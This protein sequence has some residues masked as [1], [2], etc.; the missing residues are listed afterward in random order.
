MPT[1]DQWTEEHHRR[2]R[3]KEAKDES[4]QV[5]ELMPFEIVSDGATENVP[6]TTE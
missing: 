5:L 3:T 4:K 6:A 2:L 1:Y